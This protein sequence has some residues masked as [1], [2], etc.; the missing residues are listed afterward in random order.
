MLA[1]WPGEL[2]QAVIT[3]DGVCWPARDVL[4]E[5]SRPTAY[6]QFCMRVNGLRATGGAGS[7]CAK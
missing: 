7:L 6:P 1:R 4:A 2:S 5:P 3:A